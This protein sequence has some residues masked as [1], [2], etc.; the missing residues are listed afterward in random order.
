MCLSKKLVTVQLFRLR[1]TQACAPPDAYC[2][3]MDCVLLICF[4]SEKKEYFHCYTTA[5][6]DCFAALLNFFAFY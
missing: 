2:L 4:T 6:P 3:Y 1:V 5:E